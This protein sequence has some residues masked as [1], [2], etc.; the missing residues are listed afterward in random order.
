M[1]IGLAVAG[2]S[3][4]AVPLF[5]SPFYTAQFARILIYAIFAMSLDLLV[6][7]TGLVSLG[8]AAF[9]GVAAYTGALLADKLGIGNVLVALPLSLLAAAV[10]A[11]VIG[12]LTLRASGVY[13]IMATLAF[14]QVVYFVVYENDFFG[15]SNGLLAFADFEVRLGGWV[16]LNLGNAVTRY[17]FMLAAALLV[18]IGLN[19]LVHSPFGKVIQGIRVNERRMRALGYPVA[20]YK[21]VCFIIAGTIGGLAG[22]LYFLLTSFVDPTVVDWLHSA[23]LLVIVILGGLGTLAGPALGALVL[24]IFIDQTSEATDHWRLYLGVVVIAVT[25]FARGGLWGFGAQLLR[26][27]RRD[28]PEKAE[29]VG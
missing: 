19:R 14:A 27:V 18:F 4:A 24:T 12:V 20:R 13:F 16:I 28:D 3:L 21:L 10:A 25:L 8:H 15:G 7:Y 5:D 26:R 22:Y 29:A 1:L 6:G 11:A 2:L 9:F 17:Y 23:Q